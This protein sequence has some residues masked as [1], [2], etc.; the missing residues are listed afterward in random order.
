M[1]RKPPTQLA[2]GALVGAALVVLAEPRAYAYIDPGTGSYLFQ[3]L[4]AGALGGL[5]MVKVYWKKIVSVFRRQA[6]PDEDEG[7]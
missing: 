6:K 4:V 3:L 1:M 5:F 2:F 7:D